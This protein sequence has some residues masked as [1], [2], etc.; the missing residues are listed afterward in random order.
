[1]FYYTTIKKNNIFL[2]LSEAIFNKKIFN[3]IIFLVIDK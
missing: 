1:M 2:V 3:F